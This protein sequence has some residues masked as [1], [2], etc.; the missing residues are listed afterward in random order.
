MLTTLDECCHGPNFGPAL[1]RP[2]RK[3][4]HA[5]AGHARKL[6]RAVRQMRCRR[7]LVAVR[8]GG[9]QL[10]IEAAFGEPALLEGDCQAGVVGVRGPAVGAC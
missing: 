6:R 8:V 3:A 9:Q 10:H 5:L 1:P 4:D 7:A 2:R